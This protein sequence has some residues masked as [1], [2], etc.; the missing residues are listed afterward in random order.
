[1]ANCGGRTEITFS[2]SIRVYFQDTDAG[3]VMY[4]AAY[5]NFLERARTEWLRHLGF[6]QKEL[7][8]RY[9]ILFVVRS[10]EMKFMRPARLDDLVAVSVDVSRLG[11][12]QVTLLQEVRCNSSLL[13]QAKVNLACV[14]R[15]SFRPQPLPEAIAVAFTPAPQVATML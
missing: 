2:L 1:M 12:A 4:H 10:L 3:E 5:L 6:E 11:R 13:V 9:G 15:G 8:P 14:T 7:E